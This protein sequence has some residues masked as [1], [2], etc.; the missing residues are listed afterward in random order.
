MLSWTKA[1]EFSYVTVLAWIDGDEERAENYARARDARAEITFESLDDV[2]KEA[3]D[4][5]TAVKVAG[6][7]LKADNIKWKLARMAPKKY[8]DKMQV[9]GADDL[10]PIRQDVTITPEEAY[11]RMIGHTK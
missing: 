9:G 3:V 5:D 8:G 11:R 2:S 10:P 1:N 7:R 4:A 6:L